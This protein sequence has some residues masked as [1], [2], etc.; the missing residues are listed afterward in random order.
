MQS[1]IDEFGA[2]VERTEGLQP[3]RRLFHAGSGLAVGLGPGI[4]GLSRTVTLS[5]LGVA[6]AV[7]LTLDLVRLRAPGVNRAFFKVFS[8]LASPREAAGMA[9]STWVALAAFLVHAI[10]PPLYAAAALVVLALADPAASVVGRI[11]GTWPLGKGSV[12]GTVVFFSVAWIVLGVMTGEALAVV[13]VA[14]G[15]ALMEIV[16]GLIDDNLVVPLVAGGLLWLM[17]GTPTSPSSFPF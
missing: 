1:E 12:Q 16:P 9:S 4:L 11:W 7:A 5:I 10:F 2:L 13:P 6:F 3:F 14:L 17:L 15:V 8:V